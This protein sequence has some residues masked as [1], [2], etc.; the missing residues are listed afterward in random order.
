MTVMNNEHMDPI[1]QKWVD[2]VRAAHADNTPLRLVGSGSKHFYGHPTEGQEMVLT[3][4][5]GVIDYEPSEL[6]ITVKGGTTIAELQELLA[7][8]GQFLPFE[9]PMFGPDAT[10]AGCVASGLAGPRRAQAGGVRD[11][12]LGVQLIDGR[13]R[14]M[15][16]G[17]QVMKNVAGYDVS[18][19]LAGSLGTLGIMTE[20]SIKVLPKPVKELTVQ[21]DLPQKEALHKLNTWCGQPIPISASLWHDD[22]LFIRLSGAPSALEVAQETIQGTP[23]DE[24]QAQALWHAVR[25][26]E[27]DWFQNEGAASDQPLWRLS[28]P[29]TAAPMLEDHPQLI[30]WG[31]ALRWCFSD[32]PAETL[33]AQVEAA[34]GTATVFR[35]NGTDL[36]VFHP[37]DPVILGIQQRLKEK[38]DPAGIFNPGK[39]YPGEL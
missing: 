20:L 5:Q 10:I 36:A 9:P 11:F 34:G 15:T 1:V 8:K 3:E 21:L 37:L 6:V 35:Q 24:D 25:E 18:R 32:L 14:H 2:Q 33:R 13:G 27:H 38:F 19:L 26:Q 17:G 16:F 23:L 39:I 31:G 12:V 30:E 7:S 22:Q 4:H 29:S 28:V